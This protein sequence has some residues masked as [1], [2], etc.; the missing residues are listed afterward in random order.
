MTK[1]H[2]GDEA[3]PDGSDEGEDEEEDRLNSVY[4]VEVRRQSSLGIEREVEQAS[5]VK[6]KMLAGSSF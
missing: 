5:S 2:V 4:I 1:G 6:T 3:R